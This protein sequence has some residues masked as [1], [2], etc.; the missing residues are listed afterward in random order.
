MEAIHRNA[1][2][3][4]GIHNNKTKLQQHTHTWYRC[5]SHIRA[6]EA[7]DVIMK[8]SRYKGQEK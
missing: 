1:H 7:V 2:Q 5:L 4:C 3:S 6:E 8:Q